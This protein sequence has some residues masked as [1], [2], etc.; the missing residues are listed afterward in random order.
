MGE[1][2]ALACS[3][4]GHASSSSGTRGGSLTARAKGF[5]SRRSSDWR[6]AG[7]QRAGQS[8]SSRRRSRPSLTSL[9]VLIRC[10]NPFFT[11]WSFSYP[12]QCPPANS[13][14][15][16]LLQSC[17][18]RRCRRILLW[19]V[20]E[21][22]CYWICLCHSLLDSCRLMLQHGHMHDCLQIAARCMPPARPG[23][24]GQQLRYSSSFHS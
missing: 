14:A 10:P 5:L 1:A 13:K 16:L 15:K 4:Y 2:L 17:G 7:R 3:V 21:Y 19:Y 20:T 18:C 6:A 9:V 23:M 11:A 12:C 24:P 22:F 8:S